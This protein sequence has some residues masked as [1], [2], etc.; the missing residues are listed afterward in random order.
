M[1]RPMGVTIIGILDLIGGILGI[2]G[3][4]ALV[5]VGSLL[6]ADPTLIDDS[7][8]NL[9][10][11]SPFNFPV[12]FLGY[13]FLALGAVLLPLGIVSLIAA[14]GTFKG[15]GWAWTV[16]LVM[17]YVTIASNIISL[18]LYPGDPGSI[19]AVVVSIGISFLILYYLYRPHVR[20]YFGKA[21]PSA[22]AQS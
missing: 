7:S 14:F 21:L 4:V 9:A 1:K 16:N 5:G 13:L 15:K 17:S 8:A 19:V 18:V 20:E 22:Q 2:I 6:A 12:E 10:G 11:S 3:G